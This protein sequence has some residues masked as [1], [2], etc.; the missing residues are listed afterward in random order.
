MKKNLYLSVLICLSFA[1]RLLAQDK[2]QGVITFK[3]KTNFRQMMMKQKSISQE[4]KDRM[5]LM[6]SDTWDEKYTL[7]FN[8]NESLYIASDEED[9]ANKYGYSWRKP[10]LKFHR[11]FKNEHQTDAIEMI[12]KTYL[13]DDSL[14]KPVWKIKTQ[15][16][17]IEG[18]ICMKAITM[19]TIKKQTIV[20]WFT[21]AIP[22]MAGPERLSGLPGMILELDLNDGDVIIS[23][24]KIEFKPVLEQTKLPKVKGKKITEAGFQ[25]MIAKKIKELEESKEYVWWSIRY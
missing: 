7:F 6:K 13:I 5:A 3:R 22:A 18:Y 19:D 21:D 11:D 16:K 2:S 1:F 23:A 25:S 15:I 17:S 9:E 24:D 14:Q 12:G 10:E 4:E 20:A 8:K